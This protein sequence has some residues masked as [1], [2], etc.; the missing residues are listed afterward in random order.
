MPF[1]VLTVLLLLRSCLFLLE[2]LGLPLLAHRLELSVEFLLLLA[3]KVALLTS[4]A[5]LSCPFS[6]SFGLLRVQVNGLVLVLLG[7]SLRLLVF[8]SFLTLLFILFILLLL[9]LGFFNLA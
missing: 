5:L 1:Q 4:L 2:R 8:E 3:E 6:F 9:F 7:Q